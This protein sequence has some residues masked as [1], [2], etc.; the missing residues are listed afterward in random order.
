MSEPDLPTVSAALAD[1]S[2]FGSIPDRLQQAHLN[3]AFLGRLLNAADGFASSAAFRDANGDPVFD[4]GATTFVGN[5]QGGILGGAASSVSTEWRRVVLGVPGMDY[6]LLLTRSVDW[7]PFASVFEQAYTDP[8][9]R[10]L[11]LSLIQLLW[12]RGE[13][14][15][16]AQHLTADPYDGME[17]KQVLLIEAFGDHQVANVSTEMLARTIGARAHRPFLAE[18]RSPAVEAAWGID[19]L[20]DGGPPPARVMWDYGNPAPPPVNL[21]PHEPEFG[22]DPHGAGT[23]EPSVLIQAFSFLA[24]GAVP[25]VCQSSPCISHVLE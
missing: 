14:D 9:E 2:T 25:N 12:D 16:Y 23:R 3:M 7:D 4:V 10:V 17:A 24:T 19:D 18:G 1:L 15:G 20:P 21:A 8:V 13:N 22:P 5:S 6:S 11:A